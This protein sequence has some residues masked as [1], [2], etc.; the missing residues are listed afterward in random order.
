LRPAGGQRAGAAGLPPHRPCQPA[1]RDAVHSVPGRDRRHHGR[2]H[3]GPR[4]RDPADRAA[5]GA[6]DPARAPQSH[7][8][9]RRLMVRPGASVARALRADRQLAIAFAVLSCGALAPLFAT[10]ILPFPD[11]PS[12]VACASLLIRTALHQASVTPFYRVDWL[13]FPYWTS[14]LVVG[15]S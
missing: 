10:P 9:R 13:P 12:N 1:G 5:R 3:R 14:Y 6:A 4:R 2:D 7:A 15:I 8:R 11:L